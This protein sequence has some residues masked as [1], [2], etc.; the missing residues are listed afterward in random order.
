MMRVSRFNGKGK[1]VGALAF[2]LIETAPRSNI[3][4]ATTRGS[5][6]LDCASL[7]TCE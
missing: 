6:I 1:D 2:G 4:A 5:L 7:R 3:L